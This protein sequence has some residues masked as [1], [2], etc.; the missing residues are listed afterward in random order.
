ME[1]VWA[2]QHQDAMKELKNHAKP[3]GKLDLTPKLLKTSKN[4]KLHIKTSKKNQE[5]QETNN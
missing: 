3:G 1:K 2:F 5:T 4:K